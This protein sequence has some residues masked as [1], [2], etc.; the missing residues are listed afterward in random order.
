MLRFHTIVRTLA[1]GLWLTIPSIAAAQD[2]T[3]LTHDSFVLPESVV[4]DFETERG[5]DLRVLSGGDAGEIVNRALLTRA[6]PIADALFGIDD[7]LIAREGAADLFTP[8]RPDGIEAVPDELRFAGELL[9]PITIGYVSF[10][11][12]VAGLA[13][14]D[15]PEPTDLSDLTE[16]RYAG[17][18]V[19]SDPA[20]SS[21]GLAFLLTTIARYG[22]GGEYDWLDYWADL[23]DADLRVVSGWSDAYYTAFSRYGG[24]RPIVLSYATSPAAEVLF[25][26][27]AL[28]EAP[29]RNLLCNRCAWRQIEAVGVLAGAAN[30]AGGQALVD[31][32]VSEAAQAAV[33]TSMFVYPARSD[34]PLPEVFSDFAPRPSEAQTAQL[35]ADRI[36]ANQARWLEQWTR[37]VRQGRSP[38]EVR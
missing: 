29:T 30:P 2:A 32:L 31:L 21:P 6:R 37:V 33:A 1:V 16:P 38:D 22:E 26:E 7:A 13:E 35:A 34:V 28:D 24:D 4:L 3:L 5:V 20:T 36:E 17:L 23:R 11:Y 25:A 9:T 18:T 12:D 8:Y 27:E 14:R 15:L 10:N 19:V